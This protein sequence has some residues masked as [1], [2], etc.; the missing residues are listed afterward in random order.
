MTS[1][2]TLYKNCKII[3]ERN[4]SVDRISTYLTTFTGTNILTISD[5][6]YLKI[7]LDMSVK[8]NKGQESLTFINSNNFNYAKIVQ[9]SAT[10]Y[11]FIIGKEWRSEECIQLNLKMDVVNTF[12]WG[13]GFEASSLTRVLREH[14]D[15]IGEQISTDLFIEAEGE[16]DSE[17]TRI[18]F[19]FRIGSGD[20]TEDTSVYPISV[21]GFSYTDYDFIDLTYDEDT[22]STYADF[23]FLGVSNLGESFFA[24]F[25]VEGSISPR[26][27]D[28]YS[29]GIN[30][31]LY[32]KE[33]G[34]LVNES[35]K[36]YL[37]Y[38]KGSGDAVECYLAPNN[39]A[40]VSIEGGKITSAS[41]LTSGKYYILSNFYNSGKRIKILAGSNVY[42]ISFGDT[43]TTYD[44]HDYVLVRNDSN[45]EIYRNL[46]IQNKLSGKWHT[47]KKYLV[48]TTSS[49]SFETDETSIIL[50]VTDTFPTHLSKTFN[51]TEITF[52]STSTPAT[53]N[54]IDSLDK[55][56]STLYKIIAL[57]YA[58]TQ[59]IYSRDTELVYFGPEWEY[60]NTYGFLKL[61]DL[62]TK[63]LNT[64][65]S[66]VQD[67]I[68]DNLS[69]GQI[70]P[71]KSD[72]R[73]D[74]YESKLFH[75]EYYQPKFIYDSFTFTFQL[76][77]IDYEEYLNNTKPYFSFDFVMT[78][79]I[80]S[81]FLFK[82]YYPLTYST[83]D[84]DNVAPVSRNNEE[85]IYN[86]EYLTYLR[87]AYRYDLK[88]IQRQNTTSWLGTGL[89][90]VGGGITTAL[91]AMTANPFAV[92][93]GVTTLI[94]GIANNLM[95]TI[96]GQN[97]RE[98]NLEAKLATLK[99]QTFSVSGSDDIDL[100]EAY[101]NNRA[102]LAVYSPSP[103]MKKLLGDLFYYTGYICDE[104]KVPS[105]DTR[106]W[107]NFLQC[108]LVFKG[109]STYTKN[110]TE[111]LINELKKKYLEGVTFLHYNEDTIIRW[112]FEQEKENWESFLFS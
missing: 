75:S 73:N 3:P 8:I 46:L 10:Y 9:D 98:Q 49:V 17:N 61:K 57:P 100:L 36:W 97:Q 25:E 89:S 21:N 54:S 59:I 71:S 66:I 51:T 5:F 65:E 32:K 47:A 43:L 81:K 53:L 87:T 83:E 11:F 92:A 19:N 29:E 99:A 45:I 110:L 26:L 108:E 34:D 84:Y 16:Y 109:G 94:T 27:I 12:K 80:N 67:P 78:S 91:G 50:A 22:N 103:R 86:D 6:Q 63:F 31:V 90:I 72:S 13:E 39:T 58:P 101:S 102:K 112:D 2:L 4:F 7:F 76:E 106:I 1:T 74:F 104:M 42:Q 62:N 107:F 28:L 111:E 18:T 55:T 41:D 37:I 69:M 38:N 35:T 30:P 15:R 23:V 24:T 20:L 96:A 64:I 52:T 79:T 82:F 40:Q 93:S 88:T 60:D 105:L 56:I 85:P 70:V 95:N 68:R 44:Y 33:Y 14:K 77:K 48:A